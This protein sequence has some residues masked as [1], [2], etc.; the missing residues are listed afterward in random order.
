MRKLILTG[1]LTLGLAGGILSFSNG[2]ELSGI[3]SEHSLP[4]TYELAGIPSE[5]SLSLLGIPSEHSI[6][7]L[8]IPSEH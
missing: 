5:H 2:M 4:I 8:G 6:S 7:L 3:P 1:A